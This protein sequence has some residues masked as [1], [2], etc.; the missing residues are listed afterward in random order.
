MWQQRCQQLVREASRTGAIVH[1]GNFIELLATG[2][3]GGNTTGVAALLRPA[4]ANGQLR[5]VAECTPEQLAIIEREN[6]QFLEAFTVLD[7]PET[8]PAQTSAILARIAQDLGRVGGRSISTPALAELD[9]L[10]RRYATYS[11][12]PGRAVRFLRNLLDDRSMSVAKSSG[13]KSTS[14]P[15]EV[16]DVVAAFSRE[17]GLPLRMLDDQQRLDLNATRDWFAAKLVG[18]PAPVEL[19][20]TLLGSVK[21]ALVRTGKPIA[22][23]LFIGPTGVGKTEMAKA[24]AEFLYQDPGRMIRLD[25]SEYATPAAAARL[26]GGDGAPGR[27]TQEVR[28]QPFMVVLLDEFEKAHPLVFDM[29]LQV[30]GE[31][32]LTDAAGRVADFTNS[33]VIMTSNLGVETYRPKGLGFAGATD[34]ATDAGQHFERAVREFLRPELFNRI[35]RIVPFAPLGRETIARIAR[36][37]LDRLRQRDGLRLRDVRLEITDQAVAHLADSGFAPRYGARPLKRTIERLLVAP[38][39]ERLC[40]YEHDVVVTCRVDAVDGALTFETSATPQVVASQPG[41]GSDP[42]TLDVIDGIVALRRRAQQLLRCNAVLRLQNEIDRLRQLEQEQARNWRRKHRGRDRGESP[43]F[44]YTPAQAR[45]LAQEQLLVTINALAKDA[46]ELEDSTL[47][48]FYDDQALPTTDV[49]ESCQTLELAFHDVLLELHASQ[50]PSRDILTIAI[51]GESLPRVLELADAYDRLAV[52]EQGLVSRFWLARH[53]PD[54]ISATAP[55]RPRPATAG[56]EPVLRLRNRK[57]SSTDAS[58]L[59]VDVFPA[60]PAT[61]GTPPAAVM[62]VALQIRSTQA[63]ALLDA[64]TGCHEF[65]DIAARPVECFVETVAGRLA[66]YEPPADVGRSTAFRELKLRRK[67][68]LER[69]TCQDFAIERLYPLRGGRID[70][71]LQRAVRDEFQQRIWRLLD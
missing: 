7:V 42:R 32:R 34:A 61:S 12:A 15:L 20:T 67:Y 24:L 23:L 4:I 2:K 37:E 70:D 45:A 71:A 33:V 31:G 40:R 54:A 49:A 36:R 5:A 21:A 26:I 56:R 51:F 39:A 43:P 57:Q 68:D 29:L 46:R 8:T 9:R 1:L 50:A 59:T 52:I 25:M 11:A 55:S 69:E 47:E 53:D 58:E 28:D 65:V 13:P 19:V 6:P 41:Q 66:T 16:L 10:H 62:G 18:Q 35:D 17:T 27:L 3:G 63:A 14:P 22:S 44:S 64:E 60:S 38:L 48:S 30:L